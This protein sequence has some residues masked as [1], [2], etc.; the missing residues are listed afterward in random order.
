MELSPEERVWQR[1]E[2]RFQD[3]YGFRPVVTLTL[4]TV[5]VAIH[6]AVGLWDWREGLG[7]AWGVVFGARSAEGLTRWGARFR[8]GVANGEVW[9]LWTYGF[10]HADALHIVFNGTALWGLGRACEAVYGRTRMFWIF[11]CAVIGGGML[12]Q[13]FGGLRS[14][15]ASGGVFGLMGALLTFGWRRGSMMSPELRA[16]FTRQLW[17]WI[18]MNLGIGLM[19]PF[20]DNYGHIGGLLV[21]LVWGLRLENAITATQDLHRGRT[22]A[23]IAASAGLLGAGLVGVLASG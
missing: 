4:V 15:G 12:S 7:D 9:R 16:T 11:L 10:L 8:P 2:R 14:V 6:F 23:M 21:G 5:L 1:S 18:L 19:L 3:A 22:L 20:I 17:P 13:A